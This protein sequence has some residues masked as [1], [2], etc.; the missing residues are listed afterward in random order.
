MEYLRTLKGWAE[1]HVYIKAD[2][3]AR[4]NLVDKRL[5]AMS[6]QSLVTLFQHNDGMLE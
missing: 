6:C 1:P 4:I 2:T 5:F 3:E